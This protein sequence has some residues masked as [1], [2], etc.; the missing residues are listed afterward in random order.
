MDPLVPPQRPRSRESDISSLEISCRTFPV[1]E[2]H[3]HKENSPSAPASPRQEALQQQSVMEHVPNQLEPHAETS[4]LN[5]DGSTKMMPTNVSF[6][7][8]WNALGVFAI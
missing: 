6:P 8:R 1:E 2:T 7:A 3:P 5:E 4:L